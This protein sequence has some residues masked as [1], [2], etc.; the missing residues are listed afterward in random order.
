MET[1]ELHELGL[2][3]TLEAVSGCRTIGKK[4]MVRNH[5]MPT[6]TVDPETY[7]VMADGQWIHCE[8]AASLPMA[9]RYFLF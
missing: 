7:Q 5:W 1:P 3:R 9:Q 6:I 2:T 4:D 8:P